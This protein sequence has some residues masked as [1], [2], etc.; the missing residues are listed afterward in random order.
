MV[1]RTEAKTRAL[2]G[3]IVLQGPLRSAMWGQRTELAIARATTTVVQARALTRMATTSVAAGCPGS[4][5]SQ[6]GGDY[7]RTERHLR[8]DQQLGPCDQPRVL[9]EG[10]HKEGTGAVQAEGDDCEQQ[11]G[12]RID[13][14][15]YDDE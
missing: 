13:E 11:T 2:G 4:A 15:G 7:H 10:G 6:H 8:E 5:T 3:A 1:R 12:A 9:W 14:T